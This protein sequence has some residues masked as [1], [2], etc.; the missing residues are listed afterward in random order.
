M[1][2][3]R[4]WPSNGQLAVAGARWIMA[5]GQVIGDPCEM[6]DTQAPAIKWS[7]L[8]NMPSSVCVRGMSTIGIHQNWIIMS[9][10]YNKF[11]FMR[12]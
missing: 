2:V 11:V 9:G 6:L 3:K 7:L 12:A 5:C 1:N 4:Y 10:G 8:D